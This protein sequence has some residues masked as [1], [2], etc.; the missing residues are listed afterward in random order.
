MCLEIRVWAKD[1]VD[2]SQWPWRR[3][4]WSYAGMAKLFHCLITSYVTASVKNGDSHLPEWLGCFFSGGESGKWNSGNAGSKWNV[5]PPLVF[6]VSGLGEK[7]RVW[8]P[9]CSLSQGL[10]SAESVGQWSFLYINYPLFCI[11]FNDYCYCYCFLFLISL[12]FSKIVLLS[13]WYLCLLSLPL[14]KRR[15]K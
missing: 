9:L 4:A 3:G 15:G 14:T 10:H 12:L 2:F 1:R 6:I 11:F 8:E 7:Q 13:T 5:C